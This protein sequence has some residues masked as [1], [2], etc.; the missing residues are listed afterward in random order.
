MVFLSIIFCIVYCSEYS[1]K[2][3]TSRSIINF[4]GKI[5]I[6]KEFQVPLKGTS[7]SALFEEFKDLHRPCSMQCFVTKIKCLLQ[8]L[9]A[10]EWLYSS[11]PWQC[12]VSL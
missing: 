10:D 3:N 5:L 11:A 8:S 6:F 9:V 2:Y 4:Q 12:N 1:K 7:N